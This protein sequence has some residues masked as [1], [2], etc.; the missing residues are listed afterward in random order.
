LE[1]SS[2]QNPFDRKCELFPTGGFVGQT[3]TARSRQRVDAGAAVVLRRRHLRRDV[4]AKFEPMESRIQRALARLQPLARDLSNTVGDAPAVIGAQ[5]QNLENQQIERALQQVGFRRKVLSSFEGSMEVFPSKVK[6]N[7]QGGNQPATSALSCC[8][9][10]RHGPSGGD[11][12]DD[13]QQAV[14][15]LRDGTLG[16]DRLRQIDCAERLT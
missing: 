12:G 2:L 9:I 16:V 15:V 3:A 10:L 13:V 7:Q 14:F 1:L 8:R 5:G 6:R 4:A 11:R